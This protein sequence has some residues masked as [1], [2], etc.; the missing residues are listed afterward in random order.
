MTLTAAS[1]LAMAAVCA[2][3]AWRLPSSSGRTRWWRW[4]FAALAWSLIFGVPKHADLWPRSSAWVTSTVVV[5]G[6]LSVVASG[7][8]QLAVIPLLR[9]SEAARQRLRWSLPLQWGGVLGALLSGWSFRGVVVFVVP[10]LL[11]V[12]AVEWWAWHRGDA[13]HRWTSAGLAGGVAPMTAYLIGW[14]QWSWFNHV[15]LAHVLVV[16]CLAAIAH[17][18]RLQASREM[19]DER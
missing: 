1:N 13:G 19:S 12:C 16:P 5:S 7:C 11:M 10:G 8:A 18:A 9:C 6:L 2:L 4:F 14:P 3:W 15:D 17:G